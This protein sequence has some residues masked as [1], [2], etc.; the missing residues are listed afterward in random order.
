MAPFLEQGKGRRRKW[1]AAAASVLAATSILVAS[2]LGGDEDG[3]V[4]LDGKKMYLSAMGSLPVSAM[5]KASSTHLRGKKS[6]STEAEKD[7]VD[8]NLDDSFAEHAHLGSIR[9]SADKGLSVEQVLDQ[10]DKEEDVREAAQIRRMSSG[11]PKLSEIKDELAEESKKDEGEEIRS[12]PAALPL[13]LPAKDAAALR[14]GLGKAAHWTGTGIL[15]SRLPQDRRTSNPRLAAAAAA[16]TTT[17]V[18]SAATTTETAAPQ[19]VAAA[20]QWHDGTLAQGPAI[21]TM[22]ASA[23][24]PTST[25]APKAPQQLA[26]EPQQPRQLAPAPAAAAS[27]QGL[28]YASPGKTQQL[29]SPSSGGDDWGSSNRASELRRKSFWDALGDCRAKGTCKELLG[30]KLW[31]V[32]QV[33]CFI[34]LSTLFL[35]A[36]Y[37]RTRIHQIP[38]SLSS[39]CLYMYACMHACMHVFLY[40][41]IYVCV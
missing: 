37:A 23:S 36:V 29:A 10:E 15:S 27:P 16:T 4:E 7:P 35:I 13:A 33:V 20:P 9:L 1:L 22:S 5:P 32:L 3:S 19:M 39:V 11:M 6:R 28:G 40:V 24:A 8:Q 21:E 26:A 2:R 12:P 31:T 18:T 25:A 41:C 38:F 17:T 14:E 30:N 34:I